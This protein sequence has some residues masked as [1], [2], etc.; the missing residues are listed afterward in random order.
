MELTKK[1]FASNGILTLFSI[2]LRQGSA[3]AIGVS[4]PAIQKYFKAT[5]SQ[6][7]LTVVAFTL[8]TGVTE[9][10]YGVLADKF[11]RRKVQIIGL[12]ILAIGS[13]LCASA[14]TIDQ[15]FVFRF[16]QGLGFGVEF[17]V[18]ASILVD[19]AKKGSRLA[20]FYSISELLYGLSNIVFSAIGGYM[21]T[22]YGWRGN[23]HMLAIYTILLTIGFCFFF[24]ETSEKKDS[25]QLKK[26]FFNYFRLLKD[27]KH[28][29]SII[30]IGML[31]GF[32]FAFYGITPFYVQNGL[33][34][35]TGNY[36]FFLAFSSFIYMI[37]VCVNIVLLIKLK[38][39]IICKFG[40]VLF[41]LGFI[42]ILIIGELNIKS[43][44]CFVAFSSLM[45]LCVSFMF[46]NIH[47]LICNRYKQYAGT[48]NSMVGFCFFAF[49]SA[50]TAL[51]GLFH[52]FN[53]LSSVILVFGTVG[54]FIIVSFYLSLCFDRKTI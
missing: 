4:M 25:I 41:V 16:I 23:F 14:K 10:I 37:G 46:A 1:Q 38:P 11:G 53:N 27:L 51:L 9:L 47:S 2:L 49:G 54:F 26:L 45:M 20:R 21:Q 52:N 13:L 50:I 33:G 22:L 34:I 48:V 17:T 40:T 42:G 30:C 29:F 8:A 7:Q 35:S 6:T 19:M 32:M 44:G 36:A 39:L 31:S 5:M 43:F 24:Q 28:L 18:S 15:L 3:V 12:I